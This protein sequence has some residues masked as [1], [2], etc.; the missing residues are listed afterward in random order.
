MA[1]DTHTPSGLRDSLTTGPKEE[2]DLAPN[3]AS[4]I[5]IVSLKPGVLAAYRVR[6][7]SDEAAEE[8]VTAR[9][10]H[11][12]IIEDVIPDMMEVYTTWG[13][14]ELTIVPL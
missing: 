14:Q 4:W 13:G 3:P 1:E 9:F 2:S 10:G 8:A 12:Y 11:T 7:G 6:E 5:V